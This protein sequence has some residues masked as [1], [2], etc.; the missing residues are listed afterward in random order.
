M[1]TVML[2]MVQSSFFLYKNDSGSG[3]ERERSRIS[4]DKPIGMV[5]GMVGHGGVGGG[6]EW[7]GR[8]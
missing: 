4:H 7:K 1:V 3:E 2:L 6:G 8:G 5:L